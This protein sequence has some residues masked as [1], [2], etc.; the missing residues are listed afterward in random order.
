[1]SLHSCLYFPLVAIII[2]VCFAQCKGVTARFDPLP[3]EFAV[4]ITLVP[5]EF[6]D[7]VPVD[8]V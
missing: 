2:A 3:L 8:L 6:T 7:N 1:M 5:Y 4:C